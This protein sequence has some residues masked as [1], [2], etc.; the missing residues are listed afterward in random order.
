[1]VFSILRFVRLQLLQLLIISLVLHIV[2]I[3]ANGAELENEENFISVSENEISDNNSSIVNCTQECTDDKA[4]NAFEEEGDKSNVSE[5]TDFEDSDQFVVPQLPDYLGNEFSLRCEESTFGCCNFDYEN[6]SLGKYPAHGP[7]QLGCCASSEFN[8]CMDDVTPAEGPYNEGC[9]D[10]K[11]SEFGCCPDNLTP[12]KGIGTDSD[13]GCKYSEH[14]C[15]PDTITQALGPNFE[16]CGCETFQFGCCPDGGTA[17]KGPNLEG[18]IACNS[19]HGCCPDNITPRNGE[20]DCGCESSKYGCC[21]D[22]K[23]MATGPNFKGCSIREIPGQM[24]HLNSDPGPCR[25]FVPKWFYDTE[26]GGCN[27]YWY[28]G[29]K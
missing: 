25:D 16:G 2:A 8:C 28:G 20:E 23:T 3:N 24:C 21:R 1:M 10:C 27:R 9:P 5:D 19:E 18:C 22:G 11:S 17:A 15:C 4:E 7:N 29:C 14:G 13:C 6:I 12:A 26:Y